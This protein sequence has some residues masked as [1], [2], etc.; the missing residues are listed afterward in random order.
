MSWIAGVDGCKSGWVAALRDLESGE[1]ACHVVEGVADLLAAGSSRPWWPLTSPSDCSTPG[2]A[3]D[4]EARPLLQRRRSSVFPAPTRPVLAADSYAQANAM[5]KVISG[6]GLSAQS[7]ALVRKI[8]E[9]D[10]EV[11][12][13]PPGLMREAHPE[14]AFAVMNGGQPMRRSKHDG[15]G[16]SDRRSLLVKVYGR[17]VGRLERQALSI[18]GLALDDLYDALAVLE[19]ARRL[20]QGE[21]CRVPEP[22]PVDSWAFRWRSRSRSGP[23][24]PLPARYSLTSTMR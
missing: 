12:A 15:S 10:R 14:L 23:V 19:T 9:V 6:K 13:R 7:F 20:L 24:C 16:L 18:R 3:C 4:V 2:S 22:P 17:G 8:K 21:A 1:L 5:T 11:R